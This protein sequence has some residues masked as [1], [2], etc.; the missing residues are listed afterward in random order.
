MDK[1]SNVT[2]NS[3]S[4]QVSKYSFDWYV[5]AVPNRTIQLNPPEIILGKYPYEALHNDCQLLD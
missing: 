4:K 5:S 2:I 1:V 3:N